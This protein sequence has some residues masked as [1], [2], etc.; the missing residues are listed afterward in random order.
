MGYKFFSFSISDKKMA[1]IMYAI[2]KT[3]SS[4]INSYCLGIEKYKREQIGGFNVHV[5]IKIDE[6]KISEF[7]QIAEVTL[8]TSDEFQGKLN[9]N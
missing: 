7:E 3:K 1:K 5:V 8:K 9:L 6:D 4:L 2:L